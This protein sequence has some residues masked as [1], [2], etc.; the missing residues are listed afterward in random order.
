MPALSTAFTGNYIP[1]SYSKTHKANL[2]RIRYSRT[3]GENSAPQQ[4]QMLMDATERHTA[5][6]GQR[7]EN[8][9]IHD[10]PRR[11]HHLP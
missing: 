6:Q 10:T 1:G 2:P 5:L 3:Y 11:C 7:K 9:A 4:A 8:K